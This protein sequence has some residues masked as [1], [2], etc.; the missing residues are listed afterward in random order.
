VTHAPEHADGRRRTQRALAADDGG[1]GEHVIGICRV[2]HP[3]EKTE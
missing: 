3:E 2:P 1:H